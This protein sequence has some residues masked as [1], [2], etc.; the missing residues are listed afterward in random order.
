MWRC[1]HESS[2]GLLCCSQL[3]LS[4]ICIPVSNPE[5]F[6]GPSSWA[7]MES[8]FAII[9]LS[10]R[11]KNVTKS[12]QYTKAAYSESTKGWQGSTGP[13]L[14]WFLITALLGMSFLKW[15]D[16]RVWCSSCLCPLPVHYVETNP[17]SSSMK[18]GDGG[19]IQ[20]WGLS[21]WARLVP[22]KRLKD[23]SGVLERWLSG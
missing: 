1:F 18:M 23:F 9:V 17:Q 3:Q 21:S 8:S 5:K 2:P 4:I 22:L 7:W 10:P 16:A 11:K 15:V 12:V 6:M 14:T 13:A 19:L 20:L